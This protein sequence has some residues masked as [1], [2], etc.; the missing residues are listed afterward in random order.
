MLQKHYISISL[1][2]WRFNARFVPV[3]K[4]LKTATSGGEE[5]HIDWNHCCFSKVSASD[6]CLFFCCALGWLNRTALF[7][8]FHSK[9]SLLFIF[10]FLFQAKQNNDAWRC[11]LVLIQ[12]VRW[13]RGG[14]AKKVFEQNVFA[15]SA[16]WAAVVWR[17]H[18]GAVDWLLLAEML[19]CTPNLFWIGFERTWPVLQAIDMHRAVDLCC[20][21]CCC[22][23]CCFLTNG[24][25]DSSDLQCVSPPMATFA[26]KS[27]LLGIHLLSFSPSLLP[28]PENVYYFLSC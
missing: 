26:S 16:G 24:A 25:L 22:C 4:Q 7:Y 3:N 15:V 14:G 20:C 1:A 23:C 19:Q 18:R 2:E 28:L 17:G 5:L 9:R 21:V 8:N 27:S 11:C 13:R 6:F 12:L 10:Y